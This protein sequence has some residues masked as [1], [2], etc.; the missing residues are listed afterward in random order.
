MGKA[1][2]L[3]KGS[4]LQTIEVVVAIFAGMI[5]LP[6]MLHHLGADSYGIWILVGGFSNLLYIF[7]FGFST[8]ITR[9]V[10]KS[11]SEND[12]HKTNAI[13]NSA[14]V[15]YSGLAL[16]IFATVAGVA[17]FYHPAINEVISH[18]Q[19]QLLILL[20][21][22]SIAIEFPFKAFSG[23]AAAHIRYDMLA[24]YRIL[25]KILSTAGLITLLVNGY[26]LIAIAVLQL[27]MGMVS[28]LLFFL[29]AKAVY[30]ELKINLRLIETAS[31]KE[32]F[33]YSV[34]AFLIDMNRMLKERIDVFFIGGFIS[35]SAVSIYYIPVRLVEYSLQL[36][37]KALN[38]SLPILTANSATENSLRFREDLL[39]FNRINSYF[40][41]F[42]LLFFILFGRSILYYWMGSAFDYNTAYTILL[43]LLTGRISTL[44]SSGFNSGLYAR[45]QHKL[46]AY[47]NIGE[48][49]ATAVL[50]TVFLVWLKLG[51]IA[52][53]VAIAIP[54]VS[55]RILILPLIASRIMNVEHVFSML[56]HSYRPGVLLLAGLL[57]IKAFPLGGPLSIN[58][59]WL[60]V[61]FTTLMLSFLSFDLMP[62]ERELISRTKTFFP[63]KRR[64][65]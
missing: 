24:R 36:L 14:L 37:F 64:P 6:M 58:H 52:A 22:M 57:T 8:S 23:L 60:G 45:A 59:I 1:R 35:L 51:P 62:R 21:G 15:I 46:I 11:I 33:H 53:A 5:T 26:E 18:R 17:I 34:W 41:V 50:L 55:S 40:S 54:L 47:L 32:L 10:S 4:A 38:L 2:L 42:T 48:A 49:I 27:A 3:L 43:I 29:T 7:D 19:F 44:A 28:S 39:L 61:I 63:A 30:K 9:S 13:I 56:L 31:M 12:P 25:V 65:Q 20:V 16:L